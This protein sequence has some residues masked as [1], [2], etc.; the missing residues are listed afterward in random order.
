MSKALDTTPHGA[1]A[2]LLRHMGHPEELIRLL[3]TLICGSTLRIVTAHG[4]TLTIRLH[5][6]L[7]QGSAESTVLY[8]LLLEPLLRCL[9]RK[10]Q[11]DA[12]P[13]LVQAYCDH[14]LLI[15]HMLSQF[16]ECAEVI[17]RYLADMGIALNLA[18]FS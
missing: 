17:A 5:C 12:V 3:H 15:A 6:G 7:R 14:L 18:K 10:A 16:L 9:A 2:L 8:F 11:G 1:L 4:P 13:L